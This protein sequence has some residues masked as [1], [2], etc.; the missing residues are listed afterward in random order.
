M[1]ATG[2]RT[3]A[4][5]WPRRLSIAVTLVA[6][7]VVSML[8]PL[9]PAGALPQNHSTTDKVSLCHATA[10]TT[11][12]YVLITIDPAAIL[13]QG[14][15]DHHADK[16]TNAAPNRE[17]TF[18]D[19]GL[20]LGD[21]RDGERWDDVIPPFYFDLES[22]SN[23]L[24]AKYPT[25]YYPGKNWAADGPDWNGEDGDKAAAFAALQSTCFPEDDPAQVNAIFSGH[26]YN[27]TDGDGALS[28]TDVPLN[29]W[30]V[31]VE[32]LDAEGN[33]V[34]LGNATTGAD[35]E[36]DAAEP[37]GLWS[38][39]TAAHDIIEDG[40][41]TYRF[42]E[43]QRSGWQQTG[44]LTADDAVASAATV[45]LGTGA[46]SKCYVVTVEDD[47]NA[48]V[49]SLD[50]FNR[51]QISHS[52]SG[53]KVR[54]DNGNGALDTG[55]VGLAG[56][57]IDIYR[58]EDHDNDP[59]TAQQYVLL[60]GM[61]ITTA[62]A[63]ADPADPPLGSWSWGSGFMNVSAG[64]STS[65]K[66]C[67]RAVTGW[68]Q[69]APTANGGCHLVSLTDDANDSETSLDF[70]NQ[71]RGSIS[72]S[73]F[74]GL[75][76][77]TPP[78]TLSGW[79]VRLYTATGTTPIATAFTDSSGAYS[80]TDLPPGDY[81]IEERQALTT[82]TIKWTQVFPASPGTYTETLSAS[83]PT[84]LTEK[85]FGN[86]CETRYRLNGRTKGFWGNKNGKTM[87]EAWMVN[88]FAGA[89]NSAKITAG[90]THLRGLVGADFTNHS[91]FSAWLSAAD[92]STMLVMLKAQWIATYLNTV[93]PILSGSENVEWPPGSGDIRTVDQW[94]LDAR[95]DGA[96]PGTR[97]QR[98]S[99]K[100]LFDTINQQ[101]MFSAWAASAAPCAR[102]F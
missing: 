96:W 63:P 51:E 71:A 4:A 62:G 26:K 80:F 45:A 67:E 1:D 20:E 38:F 52:L 25:G 84:T 87:M 14:H 56:W 79:P 101:K 16:G 48:V 55:E 42:C 44:P 65:Y 57:A 50:F 102:T 94:L 88:T 68:A 70:Y 15:D 35:D 98:E 47:A 99:L 73:K 66:V 36:P 39:N 24:K 9:A 97:A 91:T 49:S 82:A 30:T 21:S 69:T 75:P 40:T 61:P 90:Y 86:T 17:V 54:D 6:A 13:R 100:N 41:S 8:V 3:R 60:S 37:S 11:N 81:R 59:A 32:Q 95:G 78:V 23:P 72:G 43:V 83:T 28:P 7:L 76:T 34:S 5:A 53:M 64:T 27:D 92:A 2:T 93:T 89:S 19:L 74:Y 31:T 46:Y 18:W 33:Y 58:L 12:P 77:A 22:V 29:T 85:D 10:S